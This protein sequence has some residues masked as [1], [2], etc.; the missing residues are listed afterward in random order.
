ML[1]ALPAVLFAFDS[2]IG[3]AS[4]KNKMA[5]PQKLPLVVI[6]GMIS[7][8]VLYL[9]I[10]LSAILHGS[11]MVSGLPFGLGPK[12]APVGPGGT[13]PYTG[14]FG[15]FDQIFS[16]SVAQA[17]GKFVVVFL[18]ISTL[19]VINGISAV[20]VGVHE[21]SLKSNTIFGAKTMRAKFGELKTLI[22]YIT[23]LSLF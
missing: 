18:V 2:F 13:A 6:I 9:L 3:V 8:L 20:A 12:G 1:A 5:K 21:Q 7:V 15:I 22:I 16:A 4:L 10:A 11:G 23:V 14:G 17:M 19:G